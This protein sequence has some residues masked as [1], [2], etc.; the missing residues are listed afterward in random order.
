MSTTEVLSSS[1]NINSAVAGVRY[2]CL[3]CSVSPGAA[4]RLPGD[5]MHVDMMH[6]DMMHVDVMR[7][8]M[9]HVFRWFLK[10]QGANCY[11]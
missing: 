6:V 2:I 9:M 7:V 4:A 10:S 3:N 5:R 11:C 1:Q 8:D